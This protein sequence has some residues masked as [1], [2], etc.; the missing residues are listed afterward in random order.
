MLNPIQA[1][2]ANLACFES[3][4]RGD[5]I[6]FSDEV[7]LF[8]VASD[9]SSFNQDK[10]NDAGQYLTCG[11]REIILQQPTSIMINLSA[12]SLW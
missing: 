10:F 8:G 5:E 1:T 11:Y 12:N 4:R 9:W 7:W 2:A 6:V 3:E